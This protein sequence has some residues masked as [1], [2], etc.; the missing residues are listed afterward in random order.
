MKIQVFLVSKGS[1]EEACHIP[2]RKKKKK[3]KRTWEGSREQSST[4]ILSPQQ[5]E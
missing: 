3:R 2:G 5:T 1:F 4:S